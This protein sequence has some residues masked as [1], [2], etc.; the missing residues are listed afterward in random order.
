M[1]SLLILCIEDE[2]PVRD[3]LV[4]DLEPF[5]ADFQIEA[6]EDVD[7]ARS[8]VSDR[9]ASGHTLALVL[10]D[11]VL[12]GIQGVDYLVELNAD[13]RTRSARKVLVTGQAGLED[14][15]MAINR[16][17]LDHYIAKPWSVDDLHETVRREL[18]EFVLAHV[19]D[20]LPYV[21]ILDGSRLLEAHAR[22][23]I[24]R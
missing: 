18:T 22:R 14:T 6:A 8:V 16:A 3:A 20:L 1:K 21:N 4:R 7:D 5:A 17:D 12:P 19:D 13:D 24:D 9:L 10:C 11:H 23:A 2:P 15:V